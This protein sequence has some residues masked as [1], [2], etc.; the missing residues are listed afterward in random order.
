[1]TV[2]MKDIASALGVSMVTVSKALNNH[3]DISKKTRERVNAKVKELGYRP[4]LTAR[5]LSTGRSSLVGLIVPD[6][7][8]PFFCEIAKGLSKTLREQSY[9]VVVSSSEEDPMLEEQEIDNILAHRLDALV[10]ASCQLSAEAFRKTRFGD[11]PLIFVDRAFEGLAHFVGCDDY[12]AGKMAAE[13]LL[14]VR[15][16]RIA[17]IRG[18]QNSTGIRRLKGF[19]DTMTKNGVDVPSEYVVQALSVDVDGRNQGA[20]AL[21]RLMSLQ[22]PPD[23]IFCY[24]DILATGVI[25][26]A[27]KQGVRIPEDLAIIGCGNLHFDD[28]IQVPLSTVDQ[29]SREIGSRTAKLILELVATDEDAPKKIRKIVLQP[30][31]VIRAST[32]RSFRKR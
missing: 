6:L 30:R 4:N 25:V 2:K 21:K 15:C 23:G 14:S 13:H 1:M 10:V 26:Q 16:K 19:M 9:F 29:R 24:N 5:S 11:T 12:A 18:P 22:R 31:L 17:H 32:D 20:E 7:A 8:N 3:P 28:V 27:D